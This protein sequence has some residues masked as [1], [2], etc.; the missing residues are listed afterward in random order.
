[1][2]CV[3]S[4]LLANQACGG[5]FQQL[6]SSNGVLTNQFNGNS[7]QFQS[8]TTNVGETLSFTLP[9]DAFSGSARFGWTHTIVDSATGAFLAPCHEISGN[10]LPTYEIVCDSPGSLEVDAD[11][12]DTQGTIGPFRLKMVVGTVPPGTVQPPATPTPG[13]SPAPGTNAPTGAQL[14]QTFC[15]GCHGGLTS[16]NVNQKTVSGISQALIQIP[17][18]Q[19][20]NLNSDQIQSITNALNGK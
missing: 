18:M 9:V 10:G 5:G 1:M 12:T 3:T 15:A 14:Y 8:P 2:G 19:G 13:S 20:L 11:V 17:G 16:N 4:I 6:S 7:I